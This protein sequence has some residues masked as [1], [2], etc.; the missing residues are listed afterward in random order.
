MYKI[1]FQKYN[2]VQTTVLFFKY[3]LTYVIF[4]ELLTNY[5]F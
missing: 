2:Y 5:H 4:L 3:F 1:N